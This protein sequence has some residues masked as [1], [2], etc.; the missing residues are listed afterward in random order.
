M[1]LPSGPEEPKHLTDEKSL[2]PGWVTYR[3]L[4]L[5]AP[6]LWAAVFS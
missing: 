2:C 6:V 4:P 3:W 5:Q 1:A